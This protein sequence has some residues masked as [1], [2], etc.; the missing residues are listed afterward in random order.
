MINGDDICIVCINP[1]FANAATLQ[2]AL[3]CKIVAEKPE[4]KHSKHS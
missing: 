3:D 2:K 1:A 4:P